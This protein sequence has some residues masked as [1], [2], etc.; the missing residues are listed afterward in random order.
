MISGDLFLIS[1]TLNFLSYMS[2]YTI[3]YVYDPYLIME[4]A[5]I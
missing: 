1:L 4:K 2:L 5:N 3:A